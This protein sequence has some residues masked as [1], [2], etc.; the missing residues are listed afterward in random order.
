MSDYL[1]AI[2]DAA[3][4]VVDERTRSAVE[5]VRAIAL[6]LD[7]VREDLADDGDW[8]Q[9]TR[10]RQFLRLL[11]GDL[12]VVEYSIEDDQARL[13]PKRQ[14][15]VA[16]VGRIVRHKGGSWTNHDDKAIEAGIAA[17][18]IDRSGGDPHQAVLEAVRL[19]FA[20]A[21]KGYRVG[22]LK[23]AGI[24]IAEVAERVEGRS[25]VQMPRVPS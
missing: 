18:A 7:D 13:M 6:V 2:V 17:A 24:D 20:A 23:E 21:T 22:G 19:T 9:L 4:L 10:L 1:P 25:T 11:M 16:G 8:E 3:D 15:D 12:R 5:Q 14:L